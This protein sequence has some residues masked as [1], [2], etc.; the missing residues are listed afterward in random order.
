MVCNDYNK[1]KFVAIVL[2]GKLYEERFLMKSGFLMT[3]KLLLLVSGLIIVLTQTGRSETVQAQTENCT[4]AFQSVAIPLTELGNDPYVRMDGIETGFPGG[5][6]PQ[7][8]NI[9]PEKHLADAIVFS[10]EIQ[11]LD[12]QGEDDPEHGKIGLVSIG[13]S[14]TNY[15]FDAFTKIFEDDPDLNP[16]VVLINGALPNQT[17]DRWVDPNAIAW[18]ELGNTL[19]R[20]AVSPAQVQAAWIKLTLTGGGAFPEKTQTLQSNLESIVQNL[21]AAYPNVKLVYLSSRIFSYTYDHGLSPEPLAFETGF[22]VKW[23]IED[24]IN[25]NPALNYDPELGDVKAPLLLW[26]PYLWAD[27]QN[28]RLDGLVWL[29]EDLTEDCTHPSRTG[30]EKVAW[31]L[32]NF[33]KTDMTTMDWFL[34]NSPSQQ[35][36][37]YLPFINTTELQVSS[38]SGSILPQSM[39]IVTLPTPEDEDLLSNEADTQ[40]QTSFWQR[41]VSW[42]RSFFLKENY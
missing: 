27:G 25:Q 33:F 31:M 23:L 26:G 20:M 15:E 30:V 29:Q 42:L 22:A 21:K 36:K 34:I 7:G 8:Q 11:P 24:Q 41:F 6:Y 40:I 12:S 28:P 16:R 32:I 2:H 37:L 3:K 14:N 35:Y 38:S 13:M 39:I 4:A 18:Q 9:P 10:N 1:T 17:A 5:L 19:D